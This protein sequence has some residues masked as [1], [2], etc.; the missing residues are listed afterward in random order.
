M[1]KPYVENSDLKELVN[2][3]YRP[4]A[5][6]GSG[7]TAEAL[8]FEKATG[9]KVGGKTHSQKVPDAIRNLEK[10]LKNKTDACSGDTAAAENIL[11]DLKNALNS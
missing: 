7:S 9:Q 11:E 10:W 1:Q 3:L 8:R 5:K 6:V 4:N 2:W